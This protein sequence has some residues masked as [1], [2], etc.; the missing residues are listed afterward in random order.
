MDSN[1]TKS[2]ECFGI[3]KIT[4][5]TDAALM[6]TAAVTSYL[7]IPIGII[8]VL[9]NACFIY[10]FY[11][12]RRL[13]TAQNFVMV[14]LAS[15]DL[16]VGLLTIPLQIVLGVMR[17]FHRYSCPVEITVKLVAHFLSAVSLL[18]ILL[19]A[20]DRGI[21]VMFPLKR[22]AWDLKRAYAV[23]FICAVFLALI[24]LLLWQTKIYGLGVSRWIVACG[25]LVIL[26]FIVV[27]YISIYFSLKKSGRRRS[28][29]ESG[30]SLRKK[31]NSVVT[32]GFITAI[33]C[34]VFF[35]RAFLTFMETEEQLYH[36]IR[37]TGL[38]IF[39]NSAINPAIYYY[40]RYEIRQ[41]Y[42]AL[43]DMFK[44]R[45]ARAKIQPNT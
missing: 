5:S 28:V 43:I 42:V 23:Y 45:F 15:T 29:L 18:G 11:K 33:F 30:G 8:A 10:I 36:F 12:V 19:I 32:S 31:R 40:R 39:S 22:R 44:Q 24:L 6:F 9:G 20:I 3:L 14:F 17:L 27:C 34:F 1:N 25:T 4:T 7:Y 38:L 13:R 2:L 16:S 35:P 26:G 41:E 21:A 37:W